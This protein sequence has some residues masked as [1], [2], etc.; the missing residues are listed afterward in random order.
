MNK[1]EKNEPNTIVPSK[2]MLTT[3]LFSANIPPSAVINNGTVKNKVE[4]ATRIK[5][6]IKVM[7]VSS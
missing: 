7:V 2:E 6:S 3:P 4:F 1:I 5:S